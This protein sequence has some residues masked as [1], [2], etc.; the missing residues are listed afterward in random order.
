MIKTI[1][2]NVQFGTQCSLQLVQIVLKY[3]YVGINT[4]KMFKVSRD[5]EG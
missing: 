5:F 3:E 2:T 4:H 1:A